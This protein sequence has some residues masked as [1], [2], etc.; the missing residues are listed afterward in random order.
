[1]RNI[2]HQSG[3]IFIYFVTTAE[4]FL[5]FFLQMQYSNLQVEIGA[6]STFFAGFVALY[7]IGI[8]LWLFILINFGNI[9]TKDQNKLK[10]LI[11]AKYFKNNNLLQP[12]FIL[13]HIFKKLIGSAAFV[14]LYD[15][16]MNQI[17]TLLSLSVIFILLSLIL[18]PFKDNKLNICNIICEFL[19]MIIYILYIYLIK[20]DNN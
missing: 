18:R 4:F 17:I 14:F 19:L 1:M 3:P 13:M 15:N 7:W 10:F 11:I 20:A 6:V 9:F 8:F 2:F 5:F 12:N 16:S